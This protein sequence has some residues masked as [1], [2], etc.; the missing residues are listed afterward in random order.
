MHLIG[1]TTGTACKV[2]PSNCFDIKPQNSPQ[3]HQH[4]LQRHLALVTPPRH[5]AGRIERQRVDSPL[6]RT[7][8]VTDGNSGSVVVRSLALHH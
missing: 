3:M 4:P 5:M 2:P 1:H 6:S 8:T 7:H